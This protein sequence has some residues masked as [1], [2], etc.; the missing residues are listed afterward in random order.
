VAAGRAARK[1]VVVGLDDG[2]RAEIV[3]GLDGDETIVK[4]Y[5]SSLA[6][7]QSVE[8][9]VAEAAKGKS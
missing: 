3:S 7:G 2:T 5:A 9:I 4:A 8:V 1:P 6:D